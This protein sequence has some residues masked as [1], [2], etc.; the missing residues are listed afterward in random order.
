MDQEYLICTTFHLWKGFVF[1]GPRRWPL[2]N[3]DTAETGCVLEPIQI[4]YLYQS[5]LPHLDSKNMQTGAR[6]LTSLR[7]RICRGNRHLVI[8]CMN[9]MSRLDD[10]SQPSPPIP[11]D[12]AAPA[13]GGGSKVTARCGTP[14]LLPCG[15]ELVTLRDPCRSLSIASCLTC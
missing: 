12:T 13:P 2:P 4:N 8:H 10:S 15:M 14:L 7:G 3:L 11:S 9:M 1:A 6:V 5:A